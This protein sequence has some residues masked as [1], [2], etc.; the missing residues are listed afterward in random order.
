MNAAAALEPQEL[1]EAVPTM[2][3]SDFA[4]VVGDLAGDVVSEAGDV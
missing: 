3:P 4:D 1:L 2:D